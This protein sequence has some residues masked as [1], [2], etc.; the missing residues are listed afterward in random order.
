MIH[1]Q[2]HSIDID[3]AIRAVD[4]GG[5][6]DVNDQRSSRRIASIEDR[7][8]IESSSDR[9]IGRRNVGE[10]KTIP[11]G[12]LHRRIKC[13]TVGPHV[14]RITAVVVGDNGVDTAEEERND[15]KV[16]QVESTVVES[17]NWP[18][19][20]KDVAGNFSVRS[21]FIR[22]VHLPLFQDKRDSTF[23]VNS[24]LLRRL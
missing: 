21:V 4:S 2:C 7:S 12:P 14:G 6:G 20:I 23:A 16:L 22:I 19:G 13:S 10:L 5:G 9:L 17:E 24:P 18:I 1:L 11:S 15:G 8:F 3:N